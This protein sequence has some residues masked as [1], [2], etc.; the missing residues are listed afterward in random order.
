M[1]A[2]IRADLAHSIFISRFFSRSVHS[3]RAERRGG[4]RRSQNCAGAARS[5]KAGSTAQ[6]RQPR[7]L[8]RPRADAFSIDSFR[9][10]HRPAASEVGRD[11]HLF[12]LRYCLS[13]VKID[14]GYAR[15]IDVW[16]ADHGGY[17]KRM[18]AAVEASRRQ[19]RSRC[20]ACATGSIDAC[21][22]AGENVETV[23]GVRNLA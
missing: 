5:M 8:G 21:R 3:P 2:M 4:A 14:R 9:R 17:V 13:Q 20:Q 23:R 1:M 6:K 10:R 22:R 19:S 16:G 18:H 7:G 11:L 12:C 15:L